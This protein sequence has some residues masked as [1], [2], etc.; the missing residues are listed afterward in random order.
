MKKLKHVQL[1]EQFETKKSNPIITATGD[2][3]KLTA[4]GTPLDWIHANTYIVTYH[5]NPTP[6]MIEKAGDD[7]FAFDPR[8]AVDEIVGGDQNGSYINRNEGE[9]VIFYADPSYSPEDYKMELQNMIDL[10][11][12]DPEDFDM[13]QCQRFLE[14]ENIQDNLTPKFLSY[15]EAVASGSKTGLMNPRITLVFKTA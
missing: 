12:E 13:D 15:C 1:F 6:D 10:V 5:A 2:F 9:G 3:S 11:N 7:D 4:D 8:E 14:D